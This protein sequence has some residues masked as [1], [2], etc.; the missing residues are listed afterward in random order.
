MHSNTIF[1]LTL[2]YQDALSVYR[3]TKMNTFVAHN[4]SQTAGSV[5]MPFGCHAFTMN[6]QT[7]TRRS[8]AVKI[9]F[10]SLITFIY[11]KIASYLS[12]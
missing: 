4:P 3:F 5:C 11:F 12:D 10:L 8:G 6:S 2:L 7:S 1:V 9:N